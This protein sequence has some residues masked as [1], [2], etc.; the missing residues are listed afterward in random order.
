MGFKIFSFPISAETLAKLD[1][2]KASDITTLYI[3][4]SDES[5]G[6]TGPWKS[7]A[8][9]VKEDVKYLDGISAGQKISIGAITLAYNFF[10]TQD[11][12]LFEGRPA[13]KIPASQ[14]GD[15][16]HGISVCID[17]DFTKHAANNMQFD[18][19][20]NI[21]KWIC[22]RYPI[23]HVKGHRDVAAMYPGHEAYYATA[24]PGDFFYERQ[25]PS[26]VRMMGALPKK[27]HR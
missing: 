24:C 21:C 18:T 27:Q 12:F 9:E 13:L 7:I 14:L 4:H 23:T 8:Q 26:L 17:G 3:H 2:R 20:I 10:I 11:G 16:L 19:A 5:Q 1:D 25:L 15:N 22:D 6:H